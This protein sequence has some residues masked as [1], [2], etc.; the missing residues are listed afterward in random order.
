[1]TQGAPQQ[2]ELQQDEA[3][4]L[5]HA[6]VARV[7]ERTGARA[8]FVK[9]PTAVALGVRPARPSSDVDVLV[10]PASFDATCA[11]ME[12][13]GWQL[14]TPLGSLRYAGEFAFDHSAH[15]IHPHWPV[16]VDVHYSFPGFL[17]DPSAAFDA[18]WERRTDVEVAGRPA[19]TPDR[20]GQALVV[21]LHALRDP[22]KAQS[23]QDLAHLGAVL[24]N[25][26]PADRDALRGLARDTGASGTGAE[27]LRLAGTSPLP[28][29][30][31]E[32][33]RLVDWELRRQGHGVG[34][35]WLVELTEAP[36]R[37]RAAVLGR[38]LVPPREHFVASTSAADLSR[39]QLAGLHLRRWG[40]GLTGAPH[41]LT[42]LL[43]RRS[44]RTSTETRTRER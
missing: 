3:V 8:L 36:W 43:R 1:M 42:V 31:E 17:A 38:A 21:G 33:D 22:E 15:Y 20:L 14:R 4:L 44:A 41:A 13:A 37:A 19:P 7:T 6:L 26:T 25:L 27:L 35:V 39:A 5:A 11:A 9:G 40:R 32:E 34:T 18:L 24:A 16:D 29:S 23:R 30:P 12:A 10:D 28:L 2:T